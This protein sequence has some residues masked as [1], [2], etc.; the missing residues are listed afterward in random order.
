MLVQRISP[1]RRYLPST[2]LLLHVLLVVASA[3]AQSSPQPPNRA[4]KAKAEMT[5]GEA[6]Q[7]TQRMT[8]RRPTPK[9]PASTTSD[10]DIVESDSSV[11]PVSLNVFEPLP[12][13]QVHGGCV[14]CGAASCPGECDAD[15]CDVGARGMGVGGMSVAGGPFEIWV[16]AEYLL[17]SLDGAALPALITTSP[18]GTAAQDIGR[19]D[20]NARVL[21]GGDDVGD[22][23]RSGGRATLGFWADSS[24][25]IGFEGS[26]LGIGRDHESFHADSGSFA[27]LARPV[28]DMG[29]NTEAAMIVAQSGVTSGNV[30]ASFSNDLQLAELLGR[31]QISGSDCDR[32]DWLLG[33]RHG[34]L[35]ERL[36]IDQ[37][38][39]FTAAQ[40]PIIAGTTSSLFDRFET[41][42]RFH[43]GE[44]GLNY[45]RF[46]GP[47]TVSALAKLGVGVNH[48]AVTIDGRTTNTVPGGGTGAFAG[49]LLAQSTNIGNYT[50]SDFAVMPEL[51]LMLVGNVNRSTQ[52]SIGY[53]LLYWSVVARAAD[54]IDR[55]VSQ[56]PPE[57][58]SGTRNPAFNFETDGFFAQGLSAGVLFQ[59]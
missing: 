22:S 31:Q 42:N 2:C 24:R 3:E 27:N 59:F 56:F 55:R 28:F 23:A 18:S 48:A 52:V 12:S 34:R 44:F 47:W 17:W 58:P 40:G 33:Y 50:Q 38:T 9:K 16:R 15:G 26:Y 46:R 5:R 49:G 37:S 35:D 4:N 8:W 53:S 19:L 32:F 30:T 57:P 51:G 41:E 54:Q 7:P 1:S 45:R 10:I 20:R 13:D 11:N 36:R 29:T 43:G 6:S 25:M 14:T 21:F 39:T